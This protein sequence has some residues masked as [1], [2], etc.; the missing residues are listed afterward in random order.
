MS[1]ADATTLAWRV[2]FALIGPFAGTY[3]ATLASAWP[4]APRPVFGASVCA[5]CGAAIAPWRQVPLL[6]WVAQGGRRVCCGGRIPRTY[7]IGEALG[8]GAGLLAGLQPTLAQGALQLAVGLTLAYVALVDLRRFSIPLAGLAALAV[9]TAV[10]LALRGDLADAVQRL[11]TGSL[12]AAALAAVRLGVRRD[13]RAGLGWGD[14]M[15]AGVAGVLVGWRL[16]PAVVAAAALAPLAIQ[17]A[18][19]RRGPVAFG[20]WLCLAAAPAAAIEAWLS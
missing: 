11:A 1:L 4:R 2:F 19:R 6:S 9:E 10:M 20:L 15:L 14:V 5:G 7:P 13:D 18:T 8:L 16:A 3:A 12:L 17:V